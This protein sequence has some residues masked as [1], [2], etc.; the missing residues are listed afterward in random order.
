MLKQGEVSSLIRKKCGIFL[1]NEE[2]YETPTFTK[3]EQLVVLAHVIKQEELLKEAHL[4][5]ELIKTVTDR[6]MRNLKEKKVSGEK[7]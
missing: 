4:N 3:E 1:T 7:E 6:V 5:S 2:D